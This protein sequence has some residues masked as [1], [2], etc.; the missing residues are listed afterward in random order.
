MNDSNRTGLS[1]PAA[2]LLPVCPPVRFRRN[3]PFRIPSPLGPQLPR[4]DDA[5][6]QSNVGYRI[7]ELLTWTVGQVLTRDG[8]V[9]HEVNV[10]RALLKGGSGIRKRGVR[11]RRVGRCDAGDLSDQ[12]LFREPPAL[13]LI[14]Q[15]LT[16][17]SENM[18]RRLLN[19]MC[20]TSCEY[21][22]CQNVDEH[23]PL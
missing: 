18:I 13:R 5:R 8:E 4:L 20:G 23:L 19:L 14:S 11:C 2:N 9:A 17:R 15:S 1:K 22:N 16:A 10:T 3:P 12:N 6:G 7:T 21:T